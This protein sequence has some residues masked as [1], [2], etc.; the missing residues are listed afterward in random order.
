MHGLQIHA[1]VVQDIF[2]L[3][4]EVTEAMGM[5]KDKDISFYSRVTPKNWLGDV[6]NDVVLDSLSEE[7]QLLRVS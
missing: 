4:N 3:A 5:D 6:L 7:N 2:H 1:T